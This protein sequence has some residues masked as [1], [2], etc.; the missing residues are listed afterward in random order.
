MEDKTYVARVSLPILFKSLFF[1]DAK[2]VC[3]SSMM[4]LKSL[5]FGLP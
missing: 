5:F 1:Q 3:I 2:R 4:K